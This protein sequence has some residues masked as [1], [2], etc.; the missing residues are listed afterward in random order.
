MPQQYEIRADYDEHTIVVYQA[1]APEIARPALQAQHFV[2]PFSLS[3]M[4]WIKP[5]FLWMMERCGWA[6]KTD[7]EVVLAIRITREG[8]EEALSHAVLSTPA[9]RVYASEAFW[10]E[11]LAHSPVRIQWDPERSLHG[12]KLPYR[13]IQV[14]LREWIVKRYV[15]DWTV[16]IRDVTPLTKRIQMLLREGHEDEARQR[17]P[18]ERVYPLNATLARRIGLSNDEA[19]GSM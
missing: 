11:Q 9:Q 10:R 17:L 4:T 18:Q 1:F 14:G 5:S 2:S 8:W 7:Q 19:T 6:E 3:R 12:E 15:R 16:E 13:S